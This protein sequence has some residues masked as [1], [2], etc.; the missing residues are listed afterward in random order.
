[1]TTTY[2]YLHVRV[3]IEKES[4]FDSKV[5]FQMNIQYLNMAN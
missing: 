3:T 2:Q 5:Y 1:M 4:R